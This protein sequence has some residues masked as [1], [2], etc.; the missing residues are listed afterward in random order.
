MAIIHR[1]AFARASADTMA[2]PSRARRIGYLLAALAAPLL[3]A[4][5]ALAQSSVKIAVIM[6]QT[7]PSVTAGLPVID[8]VRLAVDEANAGDE[9]PRVEFEVYDDHSTE[10][11]AR[12]AA[13]Q[14]IGS[15]AVVVVGPG[16]TVSAL[17]GGPLFGE[18]GMPSII[19]TPTAAAANRARP[20]FVRSSAHSKWA[21]RWQ[22]TF[23]VRSAPRARC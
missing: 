14:V 11:G 17:A 10:D 1:L 18:A 15:D 22:A 6:S 2:G 9:T 4:P 20:L 12:E 7:G 13:K 16:T 5:P 3:L 21:K 23:A 8:A 19:P